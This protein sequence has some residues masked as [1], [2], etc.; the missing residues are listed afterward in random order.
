MNSISLN[1]INRSEELND[2]R[3]VIYQKNSASSSE[4]AVAWKVVQHLGRGSTHPFVYEMSTQVGAS[5]SFGNF[6]PKFLATPGQSFKLV[7][8]ASGD[9]LTADDRTAENHEIDVY[10]ELPKGAIMAYIYRSSSIVAEAGMV[11]PGDKASFKFNPSIY[12]CINDDVEEG[13]VFAIDDRMLP[14]EVALLGIASADIVMRGGGQ[15]PITF[16]LENVVLAVTK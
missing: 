12:V 6:T 11:N 10:N 15:V 13:A 1:L 5:D 9:E 16:S 4:L 2:P 3:I 8:T 7:R 14:Y